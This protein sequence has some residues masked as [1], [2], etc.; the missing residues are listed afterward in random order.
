MILQGPSEPMC[1]IGTDLLET[2]KQ[3]YVIMVDRYSGYPWVHHLRKLDTSAVTKFMDSVFLEFGY[4]RAIRSD[5]GPQFRTEFAKY[6]ET[7][8]IKH[9]LSSA[10][11]P[12]SNG[13]A[14][15][16]VK[17][18]KK[19]LIKTSS[20]KEP[21]FPAFCAFRQMP[22][23]DGFSPAQLFLGRTPR[24]HLPK[25]DNAPFPAKTNLR[26]DGEKARKQTALDAKER[27]DKSATPLCKLNI[28]LNDRSATLASISACNVIFM[29]CV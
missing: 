25:L 18:V 22:R 4:P 17:N 8:G 3:H 27:R 5:G 28:A 15:S 11:N 20:A 7:H 24:N 1:E 6:C 19:L 9:E 14:E 16:T 13:L 21:F 26:K 23:E 2:N 10:Y 12:E 29:R